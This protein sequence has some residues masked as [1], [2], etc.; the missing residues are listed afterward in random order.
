[1]PKRPP[2]ADVH[3]DV[4][5]G[6]ERLR[7]APDSETPFR[8]VMLGDFSGRANRGRLE[9]GNALANRSPVLIDRDNFDAV[10][11][12]LA[13]QLA[14]PLEGEGGLRL[15]LEFK[16]LDDFHPD[17]LFEK[18]V[19]FRKLRDVRQRLGNPDTFR[20]TAAELGLGAEPARQPQ[21]PEPAPRVEAADVQRITSGSLLD[22]MI[23]STEQRASAAPARAPDE[24][25]LLLNKLVT[26]HLVA[27]ADPRQAELLGLID[28]ATGA[29]MRALLHAEAF[30]QLEAAWRAVFFLARN[31]ETSSQLKLYLLDVSRQEIIA[32]LGSSEDL[33]STGI[34]KLLA[35]KSAGTLGAE[36]WTLIVGNFTFEPSREDVGLLRRLA[37]VAA[38]GGAPF[39]AAASPHFVGCDSVERLSEP[40]SWKRLSKE[41][42]ESWSALRGS[43]EAGFL[44]LLLP[45]FLLRL[46]YG[47]ETEATEFFQFEECSDP[48]GHEEYLWG[49]PAFACALLLGQAFAEQGWEMHPGSQS[50]V[51]GLP[52]YSYKAEGETKTLPCAEVLMTVSAAEKILEAG[53]MPLASLKDQTAVRLVRFQSVAE[54]LAPLAGRWEN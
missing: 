43:P 5:A 6:E 44:G 9:I 1:M 23:E 18:A 33:R 42:E 54:P 3:L 51:G 41:A 12:K 27:K 34:Y 39:V 2:Y 20:E 13:P 48:A 22:E 16:D 14:L 36:P 30:Q 37:N 40:E 45:R 4:T 35:E 28:K 50:D 32:D 11:Q 19:L 31:L 26:P 10:L 17:R 49:N 7:Q 24:W 15:T 25:S 21:R 52:F 8:I 46:P 47:K 53:L 38:A 29:Q